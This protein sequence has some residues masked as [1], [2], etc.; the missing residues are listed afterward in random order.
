[1]CRDGSETGMAVRLQ[2][3]ATR[4]FIYLEGGGA[5]FNAVTCAI[6][7]QRFGEDDFVARVAQGGEQGMFSTTQPANPVRDWNA[8]YF[9]YCT[10][11][12][13]A[14]NAPGT[15]VSDVGTQQFVGFRNVERY[16]DLLAPY[17]SD[18]QQILLTGASAGGFGAFFNYEQVAQAFE[19]S[20]GADNV[21]LMNDS[22][23][24]LADDEALDPGLQ[25]HWRALWNLD[26][27]LP[28]DFP[29]PRANGDGLEDAYAYY[30]DRYPNS[31][32]GLLSHEQD[33]TTRFFFGFGNNP[34]PNV[35]PSPV[36]AQVFEDALYSLRDGLP[37]SWS[38]YYADGSN[39]TFIGS[40]NAFYTQT[41][42]GMTVAQWLAALLQGNATDAGTPG[43][44]AAPF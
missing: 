2:E 10:G 42:D 36:P 21:I 28:P 3:N 23:P 41:T 6:N 39:H 20:V 31:T 12:V 22:G 15:Q 9:P 35:L 4:T 5:C 40:N 13:H 17:F 44:S 11:D 7:P 32:F 43:G 27:T 24:I 29:A 18:Q 1:M 19:G 14:G 8:V 25:Q 34:N 37:D 26:A 38:T 33:G 30:S 16:L